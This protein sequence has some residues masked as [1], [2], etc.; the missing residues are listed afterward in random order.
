MSRRRSWATAA[1]AVA[2]ILLFAAPAPHPLAIE[3]R[4]Q[5]PN[6]E[7][8][9]GTDELGRDV[10][11]RTVDATRRTTAI[12]LPALLF[13]LLCGFTVGLGGSLPG[14]I[15]RWLFAR[16]ID[17]V[18]SL[19]AIVLVTAATTAL[20]RTQAVIVVVF[21]LTAWVPIAR[22]VELELKRHLTGPTVT[23]ARAL[24]AN[25]WQAGLICIRLSWNA[26]SS[27]LLS[28][29][30]DLLAAEASIAYVGLGI[31]PPAESLGAMIR[32]GVAYAPVAGWILAAPL[33]ALALLVLLTWVLLERR[34]V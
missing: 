32:S 23:A 22:F 4:L 33:L 28:V 27:V 25:R 18:W 3:D 2:L 9:L 30:L 1:F 17:V 31:P 29:A 20:G 8:W 10:F 7:H 19:P 15:R 34:S 5:A 24:G 13:S 26:A 21:G 14:R 16:A 12:V 6:A 11:L